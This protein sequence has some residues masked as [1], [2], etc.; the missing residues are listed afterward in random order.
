MKTKLFLLSLFSI[1]AYAACEDNVID[2]VGMGIQPEQDI[3]SVYDTVI[4]INSA[5]TVKVDSVYNKSM[6]GLLGN[7]YD[8]DYGDTQAGYLCQYYPSLGF[9]DTVS[10]NADGSLIDSVRLA[11]YYTSYFGDSLAPM[12][13]SV[14]PVT[15]PLDENYYT[16]IR[17]EDYCDNK[18]QLWGKK[19]YTAVD[20]SVSDSIRKLDTY[21]KN[22][23]IP[24]SVS[25]GEALYREYVKRKASAASTANFAEVF[26]SLDEFV[27]FFP[28]TYL[29]SSFGTGNL[30]LVDISEIYLYYKRITKKVDSTEDSIYT[31]RA[32]LTVTKEVVQLNSFKN[33]HSEKLLDPDPEKMYLKTPAGVFSKIEIPVPEIVKGVGKKKFSSVNLKISAY[34]QPEKTYALPLPGT[35]VFSTS[36]SSKL[37]LIEP[38]SVNAFFEG[39]KRADSQTTFT[40]TYDSS[41]LSYNFNNIA[42]LI[43][44]AIEKAPDQ[45]LELLLIPV[46]VEYITQ[47]NGYSSYTQDYFSS[48]YLFPSAVT[49]KKGGNNLQLK[50][51][52][53]DTN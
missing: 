20:L 38:D 37:L 12:E 30:L 2:P 13:V 42:N 16:N 1:F 25:W 23:S 11:I 33:S 9:A 50:I 44:N 18:K 48:H 21:Y 5:R 6:N 53:S 52:A 27:R 40:T 10:L 28:G 46:Q 47:S 45:V 19:A 24:L 7:F 31:S 17:P 39:K 4:N 43:Q 34:P 15:K 26:G 3:I 51:I 49:L 8:S 35:G 29:E 32:I 22:V 36:Y 41:T 14:Y